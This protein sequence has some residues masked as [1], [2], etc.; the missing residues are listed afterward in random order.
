MGFI[1]VHGRVSTTYVFSVKVRS[2]P[3]WEIVGESYGTMRFQVIRS[4]RL[5]GSPVID[6]G[7]HVPIDLSVDV[8]YLP[9][10]LVETD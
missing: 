6:S 7:I 10:V 9:G 4:T 1:V 3:S 2:R 8:L 5:A